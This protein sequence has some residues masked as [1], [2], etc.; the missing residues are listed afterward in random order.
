MVLSKATLIN[1]VIGKRIEL[2]GTKFTGNKHKYTCSIISH[3][4][5][6]GGGFVFICNAKTWHSYEK[7]WPGHQCWGQRIGKLNLMSFTKTYSKWIMYV[8]A[9]VKNHNLKKMDE[10]GIQPRGSGTWITAPGSSFLLTEF[11]EGNDHGLTNWVAATVWDMR[12]GLL[13]PGFGPHP[14]S[15]T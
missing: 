10:T 12:I 15:V 7:G 8:N 9:K 13:A 4:T 6:K 2:K 5:S 11:L 3:N 1:N 14:A